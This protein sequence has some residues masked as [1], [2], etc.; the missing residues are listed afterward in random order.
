VGKKMTKATYICRSA[1]NKAVT[2]F[3]LLFFYRFFLRAF[4]GRFVTRGVQKR[5]TKKSRENLLSF[6]KK[7]LLTYVAIFIFFSTAPLVL[8]QLVLAPSLF[9]LE[10]PLAPD[11]DPTGCTSTPD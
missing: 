7:Y 6:Q 1:K 11:P 8:V 3:F 5:H 2:Y 9:F 4:F 10:G